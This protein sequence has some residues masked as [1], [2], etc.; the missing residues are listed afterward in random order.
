M[1]T[2]EDRNAIEAVVN[3]LYLVKMQASDPGAVRALLELSELPIQHLLN[4][5]RESDVLLT[6]RER[7]SGLFNSPSGNP[8][9]CE[10]YCT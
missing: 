3:L 2:D 9:L 7:V 6:V 1:A 8:L 5:L 4:S 10:V